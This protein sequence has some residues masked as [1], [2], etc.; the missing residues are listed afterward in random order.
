M[1]AGTDV[2]A[3]NGVL[4]QRAA[5]IWRHCRM[6]RRTIAAN[7]HAHTVKTIGAIHCGCAAAASIGVGSTHIAA[8]GALKS[9][10]S[11]DAT[12]DL[13]GAGACCHSRSPPA[14]A[15]AA[16]GSRNL[17]DAASQRP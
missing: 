12:N 13:I 3:A 1:P 11:A 5:R 14:A 2:A 17:T 6:R 16:N 7:P 9:R 4:A 8:N 15:N 10:T